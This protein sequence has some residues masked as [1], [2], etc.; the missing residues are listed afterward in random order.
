MPFSTEALLQGVKKHFAMADPVYNFTIMKYIFISF[1]TGYRVWVSKKE[2]E[3]YR[4]NSNRW[5]DTFSWK[6][7]MT[8]EP[9]WF[10]DYFRSDL[11]DAGDPTLPIYS[12]FLKKSP[13]TNT[14]ICNWLLLRMTKIGFPAQY[15]F[16][17]VY[18]QKKNIFF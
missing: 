15:D 9:W 11:G 1:I 5:I 2:G 16:A 14:I 8:I 12:T 6:F 7:L 17:T 13:N 10:V 3:K 4:S 18:G